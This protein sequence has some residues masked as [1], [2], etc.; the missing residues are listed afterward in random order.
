MDRRWA[1]V[2]AHLTA[3]GLDAVICLGSDDSLSGSIRWLCDFGAPAY[4]KVALFFGETPMTVIEHGAIS[5]IREVSPADANTPGVGRVRAVSAFKSVRQT[6][7]YEARAVVEEFSARGIENVG[8]VRPGSMPSAFIDRLKQDLP[9]VS[10][11]DETAA[12]D[13][14]MA[15]KSPVELDSLRE[16]CRVQDQAFERLLGQVRPGVREVELM[17]SVERELR[18]RGALDGT[19]GCG[20]APAGQPTGM[21]SWRAQNRELQKG[22]TFTVL[23]ELSNAGGYY[24]ELARQVVLGRASHEQ[25][26]AFEVVREAQAE[27]AASLYAG[28]SCSALAG[29]HDA[30]MEARG[31][32]RETRLLGH[33][34]GYDMVEAPLLRADETM[35]LRADMFV[36]VHPSVVTPSMFVFLCDNYVVQP[37]GPAV[38]LHDTPQE[39]FEV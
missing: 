4:M 11:S 28:A 5:G 32:E 36:S 21:R 7:E 30:F 13:S 8:L 16:A 38:R 2:R 10:W 37:A 34:Q 20:S 12:F 17:A 24:A 23:I 29:A 33:G 26:R 3:Q 35:A 27:T 39:L 9:Q 18:L 6:L 19:L 22:D 14:M 15:I 31:Y 1:L 25:R